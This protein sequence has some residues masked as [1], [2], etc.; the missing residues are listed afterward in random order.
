M[1]SNKGFSLIEILIVVVIMM[2][3]AVITLPKI[4]HSLFETEEAVYDQ[5]VTRLINVVEDYISDNNLESSITPTSDLSVY[6]DDLITEGYIETKD[7][8]DPKSKDLYFNASTSYILFKLENGEV[9]KT[10]NL[11]IDEE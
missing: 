6:L 7:L 10:A 9:V 11:I 1:N 3:I 5:L 4:Q 8:K 2:T